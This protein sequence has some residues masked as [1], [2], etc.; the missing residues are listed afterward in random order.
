[1]R[2]IVIK[3]SGGMTSLARAASTAI[4][5]DRVTVRYGSHRALDDLSID[6]PRGVVTALVG[7]NGA[8]KSTLVDVLAGVRTPD[9]GRVI[10]EPSDRVALVPQGSRTIERLPVTV[11]DVVTMGRWA[12]RGPWR[13]LR[14]EDRRAVDDAMGLL[15][16]A[17]LADRPLAALSGGQRQR[18]MLAQG[19][20]QRASVLLLDEPAT[21]LD[22]ASVDLVLDAI[23]HE[24]SRSVAVVVATHDHDTRALAGEVVTLRDG[25]RV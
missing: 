25:R 13:P 5:L 4:A 8:G 18:A 17:D 19:I 22:S 1:M 2:I 9:S 3:Y 15:G 6:V 20:T 23:R 14:R 7:A 24:A 16:I 21:G 12:L 11:R 10:R